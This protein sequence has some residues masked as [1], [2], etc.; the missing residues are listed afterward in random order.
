MEKYG[1]G[2]SLAGFVASVFILGILIGAQLAV[3]LL[4]KLELKMS[5]GVES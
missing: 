3:T 5:C 2:L 1:I 4:I